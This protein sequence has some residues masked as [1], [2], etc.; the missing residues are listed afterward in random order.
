MRSVIFKILRE[1]DILELIVNAVKRFSDNSKGVVSLNGKTSDPF[2]INTGVLQ[3]EVLAPFLFVIIIDYVMNK[4]DGNFDFEYKQKSGSRAPA[5]VLNYLDFADDIALLEK[6][7]N[8]TNQQ[9]AELSDV[10][11]SVGLIINTDKTE[12]MAFNQPN[13]E[14]TAISLE[15][16]R[17]NQVTEFQYLGSRMSSSQADFKRRRGLA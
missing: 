1:Y 4:S 6:L 2:D 12:Y 7:C 3:G 11:R 9:L 13:D 15:A 16:K 17:L 8:I 5:Q 10:S 14:D